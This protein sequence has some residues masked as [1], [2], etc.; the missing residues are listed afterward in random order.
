[1]ALEMSKVLSV[2]V[3]CFNCQCYIEYCLSSI[4][5]CA[6]EWVEV[7]FVN[8]GSTDG[9]LDIVCSMFSNEIEAGKLRIISQKN[10]GLSAA[11]NV[12]VANAV[13]KYI[14]FV[15]ADDAVSPSFF[16]VIVHAIASGASIAEFNM[17]RFGGWRD[18]DKD[19]PVLI[20]NYSGILPSSQTRMSTFLNGKW[21]ACS[22]IY[23]RDLICRH[24]FPVG[25]VFEDVMTIPF[26]YLEDVAVFYIPEFI[27]RYRINPE[28][29]SGN[30]KLQHYDDMMNFYLELCSRPRDM[31]VDI[32]RLQTLKI[33]T[34]FGVRLGFTHSS[35]NEIFSK[36]KGVSI[37]WGVIRNSNGL[38]FFSMSPRAYMLLVICKI[39]AKSFIKNVLYVVKNIRNQKR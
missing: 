38:L 17:I 13:G 34:D 11:R 29:I 9:S 3:P 21:F 1:M 24:P 32:L 31:H 33:L 37:P 10:K 39:K 27:Y 12:G 23:K 35:M 26:V 8:D 30:V 36:V 16:E 22:R 28:G 15:D 19:I 7:L 18:D 5:D 20:H 25:R 14:A 6:P 4:L 2:V